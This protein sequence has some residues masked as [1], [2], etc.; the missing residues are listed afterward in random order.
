MTLNAP[1]P[2]HSTPP[3]QFSFSEIPQKARY[4]H[5]NTSLGPLDSPDCA[6]HTMVLKSCSSSHSLTFLHVCLGSLS[7]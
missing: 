4:T 1:K 3:P 5:T 6:G 7:C 2:S